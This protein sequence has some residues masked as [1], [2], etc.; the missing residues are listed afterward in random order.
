MEDQKYAEALEYFEKALLMV[1][2][3]KEIRINIS[4]CHYYLKNYDKALEA[5]KGI[6]G[7]KDM[8]DVM[9]RVTVIENIKI[10]EGL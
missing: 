4:V 7:Y 10:Q 5:L 9:E 2:T 6:P 8:P 1:H 3:S